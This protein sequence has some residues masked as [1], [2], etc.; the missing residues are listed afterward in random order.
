[1]NPAATAQ[2]LDGASALPSRNRLGLFLQSKM[3]CRPWVAVGLLLILGFGATLRIWSTCTYGQEGQDEHLY[4]VYV[5]SIQRTG[6][7]GH[8]R[9]VIKMNVDE[10]I[11][12]SQAFVPATRIGFIWPA[13]SCFKAFNLNPLQSLQ[14]VSCVSGILLLLVAARIG[15]EAGGELGM[16]GLAALMST[17]PL[18]VYL[19]Q[20]CLID[21]YFAFWAVL[22][23][24]LMWK[25]LQTRHWGWLTAY[26]ASLTILVLTKESASFVFVA[27]LGVMLVSRLFRFG[28]ANW[29]LIAVTVLAP[30]VAVGILCALMGGVQEFLRFFQLFAEKNQVSDYS[31]SAQDGPWYRYL[32][33]FAMISPLTVV[34]AIGTIFHLHSQERVTTMMAL[35]LG[36]SFAVMAWVPFGMSLRYAAYWDVPLRWLALAQILVLARKLPIKLKPAL[37]FACLLLIVCATDLWEYHRYFVAGRVYD[38]ISSELMSAARMV[39]PDTRPH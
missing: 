29:E 10:Q 16:L 18:H 39:K 6:G 23:L 35:F 37:T 11:V 5:S 15:W 27:L 14:I 28:K 25:N 22:V 2:V 4:A 19:G 13:Y 17:A 33:D 7:L 38:P 12:W 32:I 34:L 31:V 36:F 26:A 3:R 21:A 9:E 1:M 30:A 8:Y 24:W 20:R